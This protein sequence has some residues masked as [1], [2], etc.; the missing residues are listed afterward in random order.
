[1]MEFISPASL[2]GFFTGFGLVT[3][4]AIYLWRKGKKERRFDERYE[5]IRGKAR[6]FSWG[7]TI[8]VIFM[9]FLGAIIYEGFKL[10]ALLLGILY[11]VILLTY[12]LSAFVLNKRV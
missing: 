9:M 3:L 5:T 10:A 6:T 1:M 11:A 12:W 7:I 8:I 4:L 2:S